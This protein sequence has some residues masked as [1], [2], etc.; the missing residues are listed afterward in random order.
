MKPSRGCKVLEKTV[1]FDKNG[2]L[3]VSY[4]LLPAEMQRQSIAFIVKAFPTPEKKGGSVLLTPVLQ[5]GA[6]GRIG[7]AGYVIKA[8]KP[9]PTSKSP[10]A[11][12][13]AIL[14]SLSMTKPK[15]SVAY[16]AH[17]FKSKGRWT[18]GFDVR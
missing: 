16:S 15:K 2:N 14:R 3:R 12:G 6:P 7:D 11:S 8:W 18:I 17:V 5:T 9:S 1:M 10:M 13:L 4:D